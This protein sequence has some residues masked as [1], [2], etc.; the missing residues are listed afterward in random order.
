MP[1]KGR[2]LTSTPLGT[3]HSRWLTSPE[4]KV[5]QSSPFSKGPEPVIGPTMLSAT[6]G[7]FR[8]IS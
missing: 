5:P 3:N 6:P 1:V 4:A 7:V 8:W 2:A